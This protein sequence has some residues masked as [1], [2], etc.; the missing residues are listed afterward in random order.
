[1]AKRSFGRALDRLLTRKNPDGTFKYS[2]KDVHALR[3]MLL[4]EIA[5]RGEADQLSDASK[6]EL[7]L[8]LELIGISA[9]TSPEAV[10]PMV[11]KYFRSLDVNPGL[12]EEFV[13]MIGLLQKGKDRVE[14]VAD[15]SKTYDK[16][17]EKEP[18]KAPKAGDPVP[19]DAEHAQTLTLNLGGKVRI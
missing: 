18:V 8:T 9:Q 16:M 17:M 12:I 2:A 13:K 11:L 3:G 1:M 10:T 14:A 5:R 7:L 19:E 6:V 4:V 15:T